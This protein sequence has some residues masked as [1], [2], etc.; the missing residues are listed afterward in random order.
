MVMASSSGI[1]LWFDDPGTG[2]MAECSAEEATRLLLSGYLSGSLRARLAGDTRESSLEDILKWLD[3]I[4]AKRLKL[5]G[6]I[7]KAEIAKAHRELSR[8]YH[9]DKTSTLGVELQELAEEKFKEIGEAK[10]YLDARV[11]AGM[12]TLEIDPGAAEP[13]EPGSLPE[14]AEAAEVK[15]TRTPAPRPAEKPV[16]RPVERPVEKG[17]E[18]RGVARTGERRKGSSIPLEARE[19]ET[20]GEKSEWMTIRLWAVIALVGVVA[21]V[22]ILGLGGREGK[23]DEEVATSPG[24]EESFEPKSVD[25]LDSVDAEPATRG[26]ENEKEEAGLAKTSPTGAMDGL[27]TGEERDASDR[28]EGVSKVEPELVPEG[29]AAGQE[30]EIGGIRMV[31]CPPGR[32]EMGSP[33]NESGRGGDE[34]Q[35]EVTLTRGYW[36]A[37]YE[38]T[39]GEWERM[40]G[41]NPSE[42][43][44]SS[45]PV[46][47]VSWNDV[48][49]WMEK[50]KERHPLPEGWEWSLPTEAQ[51][52]YACR[53]GTSGAYAGELE[54][55]AWYRENSGSKPHEVGQKRANEWGLHDMNGNVFEWCADWYGDY[56]GGSVTDPEGP[57]SG[58]YRVL[59]GGSWNL[60]D[61]YCRSALRYRDSPAYQG[62]FL[63]F[64]VAVRVSAEKVAAEKAA[65]E[66]VAAER[67]AAE[68]AAAMMGSIAGE[69]REIGGIRMVWCPP[70]RFVMGCPPNEA[71]RGGDERQHE[72]TLTRGYWLAKY[73]CT[74]E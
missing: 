5:E 70:G 72:V 40:M 46:E 16:E 13:R 12:E 74:Q 59:R 51:W 26:I 20:W 6:E 65:A 50:M 9:P 60:D 52:E 64:R 34:R 31:W 43:Q 3:S 4:Q 22:L 69:E 56:P 29:T 73:E 18:E 17:P 28:G 49:E 10:R 8:Q 68:K 25:S 47:E 21:V 1:H 67:A 38:C 42:F 54:E 14:A 71:G 58:S 7:G 48:Q 37:K 57:V 19:E 24:V 32:F 41:S 35:H 27:V 15:A 61:S 53:A 66:K 11:E 2:E 62:N 30:R 23:V 44:G 33:P 45:R 55:M 63:G 36:L 39:Q